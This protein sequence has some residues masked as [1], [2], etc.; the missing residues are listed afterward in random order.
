M[1]VVPGI[2]IVNAIRDIIAGDLVSGNARLTEACMIAAGLS[3][4]TAFGVVL[5]PLRV[6]G[7]S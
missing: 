6:L 5:I 4:G 2:A 3:I 7:A 1:L